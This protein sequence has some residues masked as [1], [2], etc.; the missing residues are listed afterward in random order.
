MNPI[1]S[2]WVFYAIEVIDNIVSLCTIMT[3]ITAFVLFPI[4]IMYFEEKKANSEN[5]K[6][7]KGIF[8]MTALAFCISVSL[9]IFVPSKQT[10]YAMLIAQNMTT[11]NVLKAGG[12]AEKAVQRLVNIIVDAAKKMEDKNNE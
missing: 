3:I 9:I 10:M 12:T 2:P 6:T 8:Y 7:I 11:D 1:V 5:F 4:T